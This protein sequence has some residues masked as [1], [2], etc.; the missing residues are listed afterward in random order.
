MEFTERAREDACGP[1][2]ADIREDE[3]D[4]RSER[5]LLAAALSA[6]AGRGLST[7][8]LVGWMTCAAVGGGNIICGVGVA[9]E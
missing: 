3:A 5:V 6:A 9:G 8:P 4:P 1:R 7:L 2:S